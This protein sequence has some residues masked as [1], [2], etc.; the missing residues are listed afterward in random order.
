MRTLFLLSIVFLF[1]GCIGIGTV[2]SDKRIYTP[3]QLMSKED[4]L[5]TKGEPYK[6]VINDNHESWFYRRE[7][8][9]GGIIPTVILPIPLLLPYGYRDTVIN[10]KDNNQTSTEEEYGNTS[11][12]LC[13]PLV[14]MIHG[15]KGD[16][17]CSTFSNIY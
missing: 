11:T 15:A 2:V 7:L 13:G 17:F 10:F 14:P 6:K 9:W 8:A 5:A 12:L 4:I 3:K 1:S 16:D